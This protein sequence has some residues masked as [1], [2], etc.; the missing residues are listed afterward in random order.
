M[1]VT[2]RCQFL[3]K[4]SNRQGRCERLGRRIAEIWSSEVQDAFDDMVL[5]T[6]IT[7][8]SIK[9]GYNPLLFIS[10]LEM[11]TMQEPFVLANH[12]LSTDS[13][14]K[15]NV[16]GIIDNVPVACKLVPLEAMR[17]EIEMNQFFSFVNVTYF[18]YETPHPRSHPCCLLVTELV[19][20]CVV[21][22]IDV[23]RAE[24][25]LRQE[26]KERIGDLVQRMFDLLCAW[27]QAMHA[28]GI[29][30]SH[31][32]PHLG[33]IC[34]GLDDQH[35]VDTKR[36]MLIDFDLIRR[37]EEP[38]A[39]LRNIYNTDVSMYFRAISGTIMPLDA[40]DARA[41]ETGFKIDQCLHHRFRQYVSAFNTRHLEDI[42]R[43][44]S[45]NYDRW[46]QQERESATTNPIF[47][48]SLRRRLLDF[49]F[50]STMEDRDGNLLDL[51]FHDLLR[52]A[53]KQLVCALD[54]FME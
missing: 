40:D 47:A 31:G 3:E 8:D 16:K 29:Y 42:V 7:M 32:H 9:K 37:Y 36:I 28:A 39:F 1:D 51:L 38:S 34:F 26:A 30:Y 44:L 35:N 13:N 43:S 6:S 23:L 45:R 25:P 18:F 21:D 10:F 22:T 33:N 54:V 15:I 41:Y 48:E 14:P 2:K 53:Q 20:P 24:R 46:K 17:K 4:E 5:R 19:G 11:L 27:F 50:Q 49:P 12:H 52:F